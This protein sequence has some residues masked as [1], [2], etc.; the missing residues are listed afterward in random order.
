[1][2]RAL[3]QVHLLIL[4]SGP[5]DLL[6][7]SFSFWLFKRRLCRRLNKQIVRWLR[8]LNC[9]DCT[10]A[11]LSFTAASSHLMMH[12]NHIRRDADLCWRPCLY[13]DA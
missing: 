10:Q 1:M 13:L 2:A 9:I 5:V 7:L 12:W 4:L 6:T 8:H 11:C 3:L